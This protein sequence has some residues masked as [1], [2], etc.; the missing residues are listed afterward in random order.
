MKLY[1]QED[2][3]KSRESVKACVRRMLLFALPFFALAVAG[4]VLRIQL[5]CTAGCILG[6]AVMILMYDTRI[7]PARRYKNHLAE[8]HAGLTRQTVGALVRVGAD[9]VHDIGLEFTEVILNIYE[10]MDE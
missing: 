9:P 5:L 2:L 7:M 10:D 6:G 4:F 8:I 3:K 1:S